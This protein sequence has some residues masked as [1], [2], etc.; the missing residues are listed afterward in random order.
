MNITNDTGDLEIVPF[1]QI[2]LSA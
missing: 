1:K 2:D